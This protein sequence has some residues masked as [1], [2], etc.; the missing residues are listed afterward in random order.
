[1]KAAPR[2]SFMS[3]TRLVTTGP[4]AP[5]TFL[6]GVDKYYD[7]YYGWYYLYSGLIPPNGEV[8]IPVPQGL[9]TVT[10]DQVPANCTV[11]SPNNVLVNLT[12]GATTD[13]VFTVTCT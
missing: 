1:M 2:P 5:S 9:H 13:V 7:Y 11:T 8:L 12:L 3:A 10:L 6:V 4:N